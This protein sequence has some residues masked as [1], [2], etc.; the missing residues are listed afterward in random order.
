MTAMIDTFT[1]EVGRA[2]A[3][4]HPEVQELVLELM[5]A[6]GDHHLQCAHLDDGGIGVFVDGVQLATVTVPDQLTTGSETSQ[7]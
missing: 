1:A 4:T 3:E 7:P 2:F 6:E 5:H